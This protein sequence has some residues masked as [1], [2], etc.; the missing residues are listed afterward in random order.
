VQVTEGTNTLTLNLPGDTGV[1]F[2]IVNFEGFSVT[3]SRTFTAQ[4]G[5]LIFNSASSAYEV[6]GLDTANVVV[7]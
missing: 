1:A 6:T 5:E 4:D 7:Y 2:D 3:Y